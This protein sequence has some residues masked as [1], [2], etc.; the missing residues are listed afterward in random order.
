MKIKT[1]GKILLNDRETLEE[2][3]TII[4]NE[5]GRIEAPVGGHDDLMMGIAIAYEIRNQVSV[6]EEPIVPF[7]EFMIDEKPMIDFGEEVVII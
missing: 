5:K 7:Q 6:A 1:K 2:L 4:R 3:L